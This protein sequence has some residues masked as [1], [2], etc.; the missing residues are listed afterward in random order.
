MV[1]ISI[2]YLKTLK[3]FKNHKK[4]YRKLYKTIKILSVKDRVVNQ[5]LRDDEFNLKSFKVFCIK[6]H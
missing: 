1:K 3:L 2:L 5:C 4:K 6:T